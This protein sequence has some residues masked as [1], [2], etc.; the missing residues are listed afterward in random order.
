MFLKIFFIETFQCLVCGIAASLQEL[1]F[2]ICNNTL[3]QGFFA[4]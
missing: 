4:S 2:N 1:Y 3:Q